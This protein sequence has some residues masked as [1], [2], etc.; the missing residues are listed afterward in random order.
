[1]STVL[2]VSVK[3]YRLVFCELQPFVVVFAVL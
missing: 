3:T 1:M 2:T